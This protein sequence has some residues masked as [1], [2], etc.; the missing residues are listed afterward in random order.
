MARNPVMLTALAVLQHNGQRL[1]EHRVDLYDEI[2]RWLAA[3][4]EGKPGRPTAD[5]CLDF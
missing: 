1:P 2:L 4:R 3:A 5:K